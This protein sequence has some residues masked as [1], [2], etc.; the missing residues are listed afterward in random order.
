MI[1]LRKN[2]PPSSTATPGLSA[3]EV[4]AQIL[5]FE[6]KIM[7]T[8]SA[9]IDSKLASHRLEETDRRENSDPRPEPE[10][11]RIKDAMKLLKCSNTGIQKR[12]KSGR[13]IKHQ[14]GGPRTRVGILTSSPDLTERKSGPT[15][16]ASEKP[17]GKD[18]KSYPANKQTLVSTRGHDGGVKKVR[19][20]T[21]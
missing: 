7:A 18:G 8:V 2:A 12:I 11:V 15:N 21:N 3:S 19:I 1:S 13:L 16:V 6:K 5:E 14:P 17:A 10:T 9:L 4:K 20:D